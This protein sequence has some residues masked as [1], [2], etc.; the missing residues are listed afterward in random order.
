[1]APW[2]SMLYM[3][4]GRVLHGFKRV[5]LRSRGI[6]IGRV[7]ARSLQTPNPPEPRESRFKV[8]DI[9]TPATCLHNPEGFRYSYGQI[10]TQTVLATSSF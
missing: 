7:G 5:L 8:V 6:L 1:M 4:F 2:L 10:R 9:Q 3:Q